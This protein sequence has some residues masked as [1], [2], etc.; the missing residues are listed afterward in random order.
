MRRLLPPLALALGALGSG[1]GCIDEDEAVVFVEATIEA[2]RAEVSGGT[3]GTQL[4]GS[5]ALRLNLGP[6]ASGPSQVSLQSFAITGADQVT[7]LVSPLEATTTAAQPVEVPPDSAVIV[8]L[9]FDSG[10][11]LLPAELQAGLCD[12]AGIRITGTVQDSLQD[13]A[14]LAA[15]PVFVA[16]CM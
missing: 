2:P 3:L 9:T 1:A 11:D 8:E 15:S 7:T 16:T 10:A 13:G 12:P 4:T 5:F 6:R 14:T